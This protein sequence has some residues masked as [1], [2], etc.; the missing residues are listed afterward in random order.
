MLNEFVWVIK[1][2]DGYYVN[3]KFKALFT[4]HTTGFTFYSKKET[5]QKNLDTLGEGYYAEYINL[6]DIP[7]GKRV[8]R[9]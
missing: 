6:K 4:G 7:D 3:A 9:C 2:Q 5:M 1:N 8:Y